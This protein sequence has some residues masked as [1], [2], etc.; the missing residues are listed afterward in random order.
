MAYVIYLDESVFTIS[1]KLEFVA[2]LNLRY[3][4]LNCFFKNQCKTFHGFKNTRFNFEPDIS[5]I[6]GLVPNLIVL[7]LVDSVQKLLT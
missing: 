4:S 6:D 7:F 3:N 2:Y 1:M 5:V